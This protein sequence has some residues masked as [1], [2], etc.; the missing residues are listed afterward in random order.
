MPNYNN[1]LN[2]SFAAFFSRPF[3]NFVFTQ[4]KTNGFST[5]IIILF[6]T[7]LVPTI[8]I[9]QKLVG[10]TYQDNQD[11]IVLE[12]QNSLLEVPDVTITDGVLDGNNDQLPKEIAMSVLNKNLIVID[13]KQNSLS[14]VNSSVLFASDGVYFNNLELIVILLKALNLRNIPTGNISSNTS[15]IQYPKTLTAFDGNF[16]LEWSQQYI[17]S[18]GTNLIYSLLPAVVILSVILKFI[19][20]LCLSFIARIIANRLNVKYK[21]EQIFRLTVAAMIP[22]LIIKC[23]N[24]ASLWSSSIL[25]AQPIGTLLLVSINLYFIHFALTSTKMILE[26]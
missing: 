14:T 5:L 4:Q 10:F 15:F 26:P 21:T 20:V 18:L 1:F 7:Y 13:Q 24:S 2:R 9:Y 17:H 8:I 3:Y 22:A 12:L 23:I 16:L 25:S 11:E 6:L 19:E